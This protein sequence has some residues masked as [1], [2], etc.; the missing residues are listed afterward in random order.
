MN[1]KRLK[2]FVLFLGLVKLSFETLDNNTT[3]ADHTFC[4]SILVGNLRHLPQASDI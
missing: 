4:P 3:P 1:E 2:H